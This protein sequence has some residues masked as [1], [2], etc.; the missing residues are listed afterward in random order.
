MMASFG[1]SPFHEIGAS[2]KSETHN[3]ETLDFWHELKPA[4]SIYLGV[5]AGIMPFFNSFPV[6]YDHRS[7]ILDAWNLIGATLFKSHV[8]QN[9][10]LLAISSG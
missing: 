8:C 7:R 9:V 4:F 2:G 3:F 6:T 5:V 1:K 10:R